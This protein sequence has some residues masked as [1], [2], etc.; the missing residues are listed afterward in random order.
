MK[1][2][3]RQQKGLH[4]WRSPCRHPAAVNSPHDHLQPFSVEQIFSR[5]TLNF[6]FRFRVSSGT[7][8]CSIMTFPARNIE[9]MKRIY[10]ASLWSCRVSLS[11]YYH[12]PKQINVSRHKRV[13]RKK[14][15]SLMNSTNSDCDCF[16]YIFGTRKI[17]LRVLFNLQ[18]NIKWTL[19]L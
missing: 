3:G 2:N 18:K 17:R 12:P 19:F 7:T 16:K 11:H 5:T 9:G 10:C 13:N 1:F 8:T 6:S 14:E 4:T 15:T